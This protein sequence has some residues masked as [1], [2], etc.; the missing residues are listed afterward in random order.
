MRQS[1]LEPDWRLERV[2]PL[3]FVQ[4][5]MMASKTIAATPEKS[6]MKRENVV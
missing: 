5:V 1:Q 4:S 3:P 2:L 6:S